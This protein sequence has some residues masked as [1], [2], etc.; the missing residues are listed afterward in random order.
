MIDFFRSVKDSRILRIVI[1]K[2]SV[3]AL[4]FL[5][6]NFL[7]IVLGVQYALTSRFPDVGRGYPYPCSLRQCSLAEEGVSLAGAESES[8]FLG[9]KT[10]YATYLSRMGRGGGGESFAGQAENRFLGSKTV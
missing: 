1:K 8:P 5:C 9:S 7:I 4:D 2:S 10:R 6:N 3:E